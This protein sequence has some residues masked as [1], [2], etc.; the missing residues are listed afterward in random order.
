MQFTHWQPVAVGGFRRYL[1]FLVLS[2]GLGLVGLTSGCNQPSGPPSD[3][4]AAPPGAETAEVK[5]VKPEKKDVRRLIERPG[6]NIEAYERTPLYAKIAGYVQKWNYDM[7]DRV[8]K[9]DVL[10][11]IHIPEMEVE[12]QQKEASVEQATSEIEQA[13]AA[14]QA[15]EAEQ[16]RAKSQYQR[17]ALVGR[18]GVLDKEQVEESKLGSKAADAALVK[19]QA[20]VSVAEKRR[21]RAEADRDYVKTLLQYTKVRAPYDGV[22][23]RRIVHTGDFVQPAGNSKGEALFVVEKVDP[24]RVFVNVQELEAVWVRDGDIAIIRP[25]SLQG[26]QV[27]GTVTRTSGSVD[28][29]TRTLRT[30]IDLPNADSKLVPGMYV[31]ATIIAE[32]KKVWTLPATAV[33][34][35]GEQSFCY[36]VEY[37]K[38]IRTP[39]RVGMRGNEQGN[40]LV[41]VMKIQTKPAKASEEAPWEDLSGEETIVTSNP[42]SLTDGQAVSVSSGKK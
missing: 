26:Q 39:I 32:H 36:R 3:Q 29:Q 23:T 4:A 13:K 42:A 40:E 14:K 15:A 24:V 21:K 5:V 31:K 22:V 30:E 10:A 25:Q 17:L 27:K 35:K 41:E 11:E 1:F 20:D 7:G 37:G 19:A 18:S 38:A 28:P 16:E 33:L 9:N 34:T 8:R 12:L 6:F 2:A